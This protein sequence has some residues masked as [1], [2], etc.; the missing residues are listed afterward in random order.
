VTSRTQS[1]LKI[2]SG[3]A[4]RVFVYVT[5]GF[6][7]LGGLLFGYDTGVISGAELFLKD[8]FMAFYAYSRVCRQCCARRRRCRRSGWWPLGGPVRPPQM[9]I[10]TAIIFAAGAIGC[11]EAVSPWILIVARI[12]VGLGIGL[13]SSAVPVYISE[14]SPANRA[15]G[16]FRYFS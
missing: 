10:A 7:A 13:S 8:Q 11:A 14:L 12:V 5:A 9:L 3:R 1:P 2:P 4:E 16:P 6:A 15:A